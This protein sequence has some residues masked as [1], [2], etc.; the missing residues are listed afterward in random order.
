MRYK[1]AFK[2][3]DGGSLEFL[4]DDLMKLMSDIEQSIITCGLES[5]V[6]VDLQVTFQVITARALAIYINQVDS[7]DRIHVGRIYAN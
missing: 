2:N 7:T 5:S 6:P 1:A 3:V 4:S